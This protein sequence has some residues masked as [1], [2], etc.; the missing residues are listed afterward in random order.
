MVREATRTKE[1]ENEEVRLRRRLSSFVNE[2][3]S[4][5]KQSSKFPEVASDWRIKSRSQA[6][7]N[8]RRERSWKPQSSL[9][10]Y[11]WHVAKLFEIIDE[12]ADERHIM[13]HLHSSPPLHMRRTI[14][15]Y[16]YPTVEDSSQRDQDQVVCRGTRSKND[17]D[18]MA[19]VVMVDQLW[20]WILDDSQCFPSFSYSHPLSG[21]ISAGIKNDS[22]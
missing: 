4:G 10:Q 16:Y 11:L 12:A 21:A 14:D 19:R 3:G 17:P 9:A 5:R 18:A 1:K 22:H 20:L 8:T 2:D 6:A 15:Q 7:P 13:E